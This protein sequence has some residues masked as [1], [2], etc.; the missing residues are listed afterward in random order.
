MRLI[1]L[2][3]LPLTL[4]IVP[5]AHGQGTTETMVAVSGAAL[6]WNDISIPGFAPGV[7]L[8]A[9]HGNPDSAEAYALRLSFPDGYRFPPHWHP[10]A[11]NV[12][13]L[14][15]TLLLT[16]GDRVQASGVE[17][18]YGVGDYLYLPATQPHYGGARGRTVL[19]LHGMGPFV[20][21][22]AS[23]AATPAPQ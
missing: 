12:T 23:P 1:A 19:Q 3:C 8:A 13:V 15:G 6:V 14:E 18:S 10:M 16:M 21:N 4:V 22:L 20:I 5:G 9:I 17:K 7:R 11:E 2:F